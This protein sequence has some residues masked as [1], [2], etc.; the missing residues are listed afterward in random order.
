MEQLAD[1]SASQDEWT[2]ETD[3]LLLKAIQD[4]SGDILASIQ[5]IDTSLSD[6]HSSVMTL[7]LRTGHA[8]ASF[9]ELC[10]TQ[11][12]QQVFYPTGNPSLLIPWL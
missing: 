11:F 2:L 4:M 10:Q 3:R 6:L 12:I 9:T 7:S 1:W 5:R 8:A